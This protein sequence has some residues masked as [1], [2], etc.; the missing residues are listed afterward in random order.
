MKKVRA[1]IGTLL[2]VIAMTLAVIPGSAFAE[3]ADP[4]VPAPAKNSITLTKYTEGTGTA[5]QT[6]GLE[7]LRPQ[8]LRLKASRSSCTRQI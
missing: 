2:L 5:T 4:T 3:D 7:V 8:A 6:D 1:R